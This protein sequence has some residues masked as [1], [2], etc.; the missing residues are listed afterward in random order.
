MSSFNYSNIEKKWLQKWSLNGTYTTDLKDNSKEKFYNLVMFPYPSSYTLHTGH[1]YTYSGC[2]VN[3]KFKRLMGY[4]VFQ[5]MGFD[6]F[7]IH[8]E[9][10]ALKVNKHPKEVVAE[11]VINFTKQ[12][13]SLGTSFDWEHTVNTT[14]PQYYKWTQWLFIT[15]YKMGLA[16]KKE[17]QV[18]WCP[19]C[20]T[21]LSDEMVINGKCERCSSEVIKK[22][23]SQWF[24]LISKYSQRLLDDMDKIDWPDSTLQL[25][26]NWIGRSTG[27]NIRFEIKEEMKSDDKDSSLKYVE[28]FTTKPETIYG[29]KFIVVSVQHPLAIKQSGLST[30]AEFIRKTESMTEVDNQK[31]K[32]GVFLNIHALNPFT[33]ERIP[34][35]AANYVLASYGTGALM[36]VP[37]HDVRD[38]EFAQKYN[39]ESKEV[40]LTESSYEKGRLISSGEFNGKSVEEA[41]KLIIEKLEKFKKGGEQIT[42][43]LR[44]WLISRQR[45]WGPPIPIIYC[46]KCGEQ[47][48][49]NLP[50]MLPESMDVLPSSDGLSPLARI[51][52]F[53]NVKCPKCGGDAK[54]DTD[55]LDNFVDSSWYYLRYPSALDKIRAFDDEL[56][57]KW[58]PVD[59]YIGGNEHAVLH[60]MYTR[61]II[62]ALSDGG[63]IDFD[64]PFKKF[65]AQGHILKEGKKMSKSIGNIVV[66][67]EYIQKYG[68]DVFRLYILFIAAFTDGG[69][70]SDANILGMVRFIEK[71]WNIDEINGEGKETST[72]YFDHKIN[73]IKNQLEALKFNSAIAS[74]MEYWNEFSKTAKQFTPKTVQKLKEDFIVMLSPFAPFITH[75][76]WAEKF[77][78]QGFVMNASWPKVLENKEPQNVIISLQINGK[79]KLAVEVRNDLLK[80][81]IIQILIKNPEAYKFFKDSKVVNEIYVPNKVINILT[82]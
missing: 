44:D 59:L 58:L 53:V 66:P 77:H 55:V 73:I 57:K 64:E 74:L 65:V 51:E 2:D 24:F 19:S 63:Y 72:K 35:Y 62:K 80:E 60:L 37:A 3:G 34:V 39:I 79:H 69:D 43:K 41:R 23:L 13:M 33:G 38:Y 25:Q 6:A 10:Y 5:P 17:A 27:A 75:E 61:F 76:I 32:E 15:L 16:Q 68:S 47:V 14:T 18:N 42:Y 21:V 28:V 78:K 9:N 70:F 11:N 46:D 20:K 56:T 45:Y 4:N 22:N 48:D 30:V 52:S 12:I 29:V 36:G 50:V 26:R 40:V 54:R 71:I 7:G 49:E 1:A 67:D 8:G 82:A 31:E 81:E